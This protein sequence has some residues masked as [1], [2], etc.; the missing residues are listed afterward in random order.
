MI[1]NKTV[2]LFGL[3]IMQSI[4]LG[5]PRWPETPALVELYVATL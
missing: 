3:L 1:G 2:K 4:F 5:Q